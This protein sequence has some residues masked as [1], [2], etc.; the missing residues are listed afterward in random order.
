VAAFLLVSGFNA[1]FQIIYGPYGPFFLPAGWL[2]PSN[3]VGL[4]AVLNVSG[5]ELLVVIG[6]HK[7]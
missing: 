3:A 4:H 5:H 1:A 6:N 7:S 2:Q